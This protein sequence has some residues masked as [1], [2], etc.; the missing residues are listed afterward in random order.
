MFQTA[1]LLMHGIGAVGALV[2]GFLALTY[3]NGTSKHHLIGK[4]YLLCW[5]L[6]FIGGA[7]VGSWR[8]GLSI[9]EILN[10]L[11]F[12]STLFAYAMV[13]FRKRIGRVWLRR[14]Y[15]WMITSLTFVVVATV[16]V[17]LRHTLDGLPIWVVYLSIVAPAPIVNWYVRRLDRRYGFA[18]SAAPSKA[19]AELA[20]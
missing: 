6:L 4:L 12:A 1:I 11:G 7:I 13:L 3:P 5:L 20:G 14:H 17:V 9:F 10:I 16:Q 19:A 8:P 15:N 18:K 2:T